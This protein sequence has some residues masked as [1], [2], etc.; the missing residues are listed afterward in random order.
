MVEQWRPVKGYEGKYIVS[1]NGNVMSVPRSYTDELGR[2][3]VVDG[4]TLAKCDDARGYDRVRLGDSGMMRVHRLVA[5]AF[6]PNPLNLPEVNHKDGNKKNNC[7]TNLEWV[8]HQG[9]VVHAVEAGLFGE[10]AKKATPEIV[11]AIR[12]EYIP[13]DREHSTIAL[14]KKYGIDPAYVWRII[15]GQKRKRLP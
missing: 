10:R 11:E 6:I 12:A 1:N 5:E 2:N 15:N 8:T 14:G 13:Y 4:I 3:Y 9:N 7:V